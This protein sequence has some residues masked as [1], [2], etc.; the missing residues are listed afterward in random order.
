VDWTEERLK[1]IPVR[2]QLTSKALTRNKVRNFPLAKQSEKKKLVRHFRPINGRRVASGAATTERQEK[3]REIHMPSYE[4]H[5]AHKK[6]NVASS[7]EEN[8]EKREKHPASRA[9]DRP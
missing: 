7:Y 2:S 4:S 1:K 3:G 6:G 8:E 9:L 5:S